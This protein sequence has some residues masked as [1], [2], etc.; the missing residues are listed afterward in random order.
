V[1]PIEAPP[2]PPPP[3][4]PEPGLRAFQALGALEPAQAARVLTWACAFFGVPETVRVGVLRAEAERGKPR[5][6]AKR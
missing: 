4:A 6:K 3:D 5:R 1:S 2:R